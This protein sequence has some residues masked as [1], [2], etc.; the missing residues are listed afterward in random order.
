[1]L[2][3]ID[4]GTSNTRVA[5]WDDSAGAARGLFIPDI[6]MAAIQKT[7]DHGDVEVPF[8]PSLITYEGKHVW[9]GRQVFDKGLS[10][11]SA[12]FRWMKRYIANR[13][14]LPR[15]I[16]GKSIRYSDA[17]RDYL[18]H[19]LTRALT[20]TDMNEVETAFTLPVEA[21]EHYQEWLSQVAEYAGIRRFRFLDEASAAALGYGVHAQS[22]HVCMVFDFGGGTLDVSIVR[23]EE[24]AKGY[25][26]CHVLGK[27][28]ADI[29]GATIDQ[30]LYRD[31]LARNGKSPESVSHFSGSI[32]GALQQAK[33][34]LTSLD[35]VDVE[36]RDPHTEQSL[37]ASYS[38]SA[39]EDLLE[40][41]GMFETI[42][43]AMDR[44]LLDAGER[45]YDSSSIHDV[46][47]VGGSSLMPCV[48]R[49]VRQRFGTRV[50]SHRPLDAVALGAAAFIGGVELY[51]HIQHR[52][53]LRYYNRTKGR[54]EFLTIVEA[55]TPYPCQGPV[56]QVTVCASYDDQEYLGLE[57]YEIS[58]EDGASH[59]GE[60]KFDL[61]FD[62]SGRVHFREREASDENF[63]YFWINEHCPS[64][65][66]A[67]PLAQRGDKRFPVSFTVDGNKRLCV[68]VRD[69]QTGR[70]LM[71]DKPLIKLR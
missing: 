27:G 48:R 63:R 8:V 66:H 21:F 43:R 51:D 60:A 17:G 23:M 52:Y 42:N 71:K 45:G 6:S 57:V 55:G 34:T 16:A 15:K 41:R 70:V 31:F 39:M 1:M 22:G 59:D 69:V 5:V 62:P 3:S 67:S 61:I 46:L 18:V 56:R 7:V 35:S 11:S 19:V 53:A 64:F 13:L 49:A 32:L 47:L 37:C 29:G 2:L 25:R 40:E 28:G 12:T 36:V 65:V 26:K 4:F 38:R 58:P 44:A 9:I 24:Q 10:E 68:S 30:W 14:D 54:H 33:E 50:R 20:T